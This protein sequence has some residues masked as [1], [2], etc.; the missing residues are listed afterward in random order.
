[1]IFWELDVDFKVLFRPN[2]PNAVNGRVVG[3]AVIDSI[4]TDV[5]GSDEVLESARFKLAFA[6]VRQISQRVRNERIHSFEA[7]IYDF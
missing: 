4:L 2:G 7:S 6:N 1:M 5:R 3:E